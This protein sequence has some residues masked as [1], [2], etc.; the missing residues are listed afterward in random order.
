MK[1][2]KETPPITAPL[3]S[4]RLLFAPVTPVSSHCH[5]ILL[6]LIL[7]MFSGSAWAAGAAGGGAAATERKMLVLVA[8]HV[9]F[10]DW[11]MPGLAHIRRA[12]RMGALG[13][14]VTRSLDHASST[15]AIA[16]LGSGL[17]AAATQTGRLAFNP[18]EEYNGDRAG[19]L[20]AETTGAKAPEGGVVHIG[21]PALREANADTRWGARPGALGGLLAAA[22]IRTAAIG[23]SDYGS[24]PGRTAAILAMDESGK[25]PAGDVSR[26]LLVE[27]DAFPGGAATDI[28]AFLDAVFDALETAGFVVA[29]FGDMARAEKFAVA[30][31]EQPGT[32]AAAET[33]RKAAVMKL[34][35]VLASLL[36]EL[37]LETVQLIV[38]SPTPRLSAIRNRETLTPVL[39]LGAGVVS[40]ASVLTSDS[41][42]RRGIVMNTD[43]APHA[44][45]FF[46][47]GPAPDF[48][49]S[50]FE[51]IPMSGTSAFVG[52]VYR[53][54]VFVEGMYGMLKK[55]I[56]WH[57]AMLV[58]CFATTLLVA[59]AGR[60]W[61]VALSW[62]IIFT[63]CMF[64]SFLFA[65]GL[66]Y[67]RGAGVFVAGYFGICLLMAGAAS[68]MPAPQH[69][70][71]FIAAAYFFAL[72]TD[73]LTGGELIGNSVLGYYPQVGARF[74]GIGNE[75]MGF[76]ISAPVV[77][78]GLA[79]DALP[80]WRGV[81]KVV[82]GV[83]FAGAVYVVGSPSLGANFGGL[84]SCSVGYLFMML[85]V[86]EGRLNWRTVLY[87][88]LAAGL[89]VSAFVAAD[90]FLGGGDSHVT[91]LIA[92]VA[93]EGGAPELVKVVWR[94]L[95]VNL[96]LIRVSFWSAIFIISLAIAFAAHYFP[97]DRFRRLFE[98]NPN[99][100][101][102]YVASLLGALAAFAVND[103][104]IVPGATAFI[105]PTA[106]MF[107]IFFN[108][109]EPQEE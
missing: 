19:G 91:K 64:L 30:N 60:G 57:L 73:Q 1:Y 90:Y 37:D 76:M 66:P 39:A 9:S 33:A 26:G 55:V 32:A 41:T 86:Q 107:Y 25:A 6:T 24:D 23:N 81:I 16:T 43:F 104:G 47:I 100:R 49:G 105:I 12:E 5:V 70:F 29:D 18:D 98:L 99:F 20:Y 27:S 94:K 97:V 79:L 8:D 88:L 35:S 69:K 50:S 89:F 101:H 52:D 103:S 83:L 108:M 53:R 63:S 36:A 48:V 44:C 42:R 74:Y 93:G 92:R 34:D 17:R 40:G 85:L 10:D 75:F 21:W 72:I 61:R 14:L 2:A 51:F 96:R 38:I 22:D 11:T 67:D 80:R 28:P 65:A 3:A 56:I 68:L 4:L 87:V 7:L 62:L 71:A 102:A 82:M 46:G 45:A 54:D 59:R 13:L 106:A 109:R 31:S 58:V 15:A 84:I 95:S 78:A 77:L